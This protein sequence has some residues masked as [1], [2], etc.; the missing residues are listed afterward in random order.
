MHVMVVP[1]ITVEKVHM[2]NHDIEEMIREK[3]NKSSQVI[4][5]IEPYYK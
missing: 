2:L 3:I 4:V 1:N 5:H